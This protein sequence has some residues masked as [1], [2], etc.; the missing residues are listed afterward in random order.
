ML[1]TPIIWTII[2]FSWYVDY[3]ERK[4]TECWER[5]SKFF[6]EHLDEYPEA[7]ASWGMACFWHSQQGYDTMYKIKE[8]E[9]YG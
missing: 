1:L 7:A 8:A 5:I 6:T 4:E 2:Y 9:F 3:K